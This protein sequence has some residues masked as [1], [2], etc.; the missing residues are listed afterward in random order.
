MFSHYLITRFNLKTPMWDVTKNNETLLTDEW[1]EHRLWLFE[2]F[3]FPSVAAQVNKNFQWL[4]YFD[5]TTPEAYRKEVDRII[6]NNKNVRIFYIEGMPAFYPE[7]QKHIAAEAAG[8][9]YLITSMLDND[10]CISRNYIDEVQKQFDKQDYMVIDLIKGYSLQ[11]KPVIMLGKK[12]HIYNPFISLIEKNDNPMTVWSKGH[13]HWKKETRIKHMTGK[14]LWLSI[15]H[16]KNKVN[17][18]D[19]YGNINWDDVKKE[20]IVSDAI[21]ATIRREMLPFSQW[22]WTSFKNRLY[23]N[24]VLFNK[25]F[26]KSIGIYKLKK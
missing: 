24:W 8:S 13:N 22:R 9:P 6:G 15:I 3:C 19:G 5:V 7:I 18:F 12:E 1:L 10:D 14:R 25:L 2:N 16:E 11:I 4:I 20:F 23:V 26:K 21:D 17:E